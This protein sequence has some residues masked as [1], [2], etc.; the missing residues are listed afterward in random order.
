M[1][2]PEM[3]TRLIFGLQGVCLIRKRLNLEKE[4]EAQGQILAPQPSF[5]LWAA[6]AAQNLPRSQEDVPEANLWDVS[7]WE[8]PWCQT[9]PSPGYWWL[10]GVG[11]R[12]GHQG[13]SQEHLASNAVLRRWILPRSCPDS[14]QCNQV[15]CRS[16]WPSGRSQCLGGDTTM[17]CLL[18]GGSV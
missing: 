16:S 7:H 14:A 5:P 10:L 4:A 3:E 17:Y 13:T 15:T 6:L 18:A 12:Q 11:T 2:L 1:A 9:Q 8:I